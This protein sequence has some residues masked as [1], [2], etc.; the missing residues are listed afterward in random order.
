MSNKATKHMA[1]GLLLTG[2]VA[3]AGATLFAIFRKQ[4]REKVY[5]EEEIKKMSELDDMLTEDEQIYGC[6]TRCDACDAA[7][8]CGSTEQVSLEQTDVPT[9]PEDTAPAQ[10]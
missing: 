1:L 10:A 2:A 7:D 4:H 9:E 5:R 6:D 3:G 8:V